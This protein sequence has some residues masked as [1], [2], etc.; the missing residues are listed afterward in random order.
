M[1]RYA[2]KP[3]LVAMGV[4][5]LLGLGL[6]AATG[7]FRKTD[8]SHATL[9]ELE[10]KIVG[11]TDGRIW[12]AYG[13]K[14]REKDRFENAAKAYQRA[15]ELQP[16]LADARLK[17]GLTLGQYSKDAFFDY[18]GRLVISYPKLAVN[19]MARPEL[20]ALHADPRWE[21]A[22]AAAMAQAVD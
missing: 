2:R 8:L 5:A 6:F 22:A 11:S 9:E 15:L 17:Q 7:Q 21:P 1:T 16:D 18:V 19:L 13:D 10:K 14:L 20:S 3:A 4:T 12:V